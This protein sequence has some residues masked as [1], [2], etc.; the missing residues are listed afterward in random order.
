MKIPRKREIARTEECEV[1]LSITENLARLTHDGGLHLVA[2]TSRM[3]VVP[4]LMEDFRELL[5]SVL[6]ELER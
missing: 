1:R 4:E 2:G 3:Y 5:L 6:M